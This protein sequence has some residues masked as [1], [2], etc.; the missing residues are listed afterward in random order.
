MKV[1]ET[2]SDGMKIVVLAVTCS[3]VNHGTWCDWQQAKRTESIRVV[4]QNMSEFLQFGRV[5]DKDRREVES[6]SNSAGTAPMDV[7]AVGKGKGNCK[8]CFV[9]GRPGHAAKDCRLNQGKG[10]G[11]SKWKG[12]STTDKNSPAKFERECRHCVA[13]KATN[14]QT[15]GS[16]WQKRQTGKST[17]S[18]PM[19]FRRQRG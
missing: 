6:E 2:F 11:H 15:A 9:C 19:E 1:F 14:G 18:R 5:F 3:R 13:R 12:K 7:D 10:K 16:D 17:P 4:R 8:G